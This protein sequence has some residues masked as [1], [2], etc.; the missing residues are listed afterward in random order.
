[1]S[2]IREVVY[3]VL[4]QGVQED[5]PAEPL[6]TGCYQVNINGTGSATF[7]VLSDGTVVQRKSVADVHGTAP[8]NRLKQT[9]R[10]R[11][12]AES[13]RRTRAAA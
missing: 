10:G 5:R 1:V 12:G 2:D 9:A 4:P 7:D 3:G 6:T 11:S 8:N 13:L